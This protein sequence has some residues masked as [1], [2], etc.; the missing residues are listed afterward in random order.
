MRNE[1]MSPENS[2]LNDSA[3]SVFTG[4]FILPA[5][6]GRHSVTYY[7]IRHKKLLDLPTIPA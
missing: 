7:Q 4:L 3:V 5:A 2:I 6:Q 1:K